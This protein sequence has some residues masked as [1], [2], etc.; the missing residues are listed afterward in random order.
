MKVPAG[1]H[2]F[3]DPNGYKIGI[4]GDQVLKLGQRLVLHGAK[5]YTPTRN[6]TSADV[7]QVKIFQKKYKLL[8]DGIPG[9]ITLAALAKDPV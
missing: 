2:N 3:N 8:V 5:N 6:Y 1:E 4:V 9:P 7:N